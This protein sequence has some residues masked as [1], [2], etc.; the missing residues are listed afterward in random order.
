M[1][2]EELIELTQHGLLRIGFHPKLT[3][4]GGL[5]PTERDHFLETLHRATLGAEAGSELRYS[6]DTGKCYIVR[7][8]S[9]RRRVSIE[10]MAAA[11]ALGDLSLPGPEDLPRIT[12]ITAADLSGPAGEVPSVP[13]LVERLIGWLGRARSAGTRGRPSLAVLSDPLAG[14]GAVQTWALL[15][16]LERLGQIVQIV[17]LT[18]DPTVVAWARERE[19][20]DSLTLVESLVLTSV[21][22]QRHA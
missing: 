5:D 18:D 4:V 11:R 8:S 9:G 21:A 2:V 17:Y 20:T 6:D 3:V 19:H 12:Q 13:T 15:D 10:D 1:I 22:Q 7:R 16:A 14:L